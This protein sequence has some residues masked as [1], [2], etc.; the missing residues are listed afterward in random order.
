[1]YWASSK[2]RRA[3]PF[4]LHHSPFD[5]HL[6]T[7]NFTRP[8]A[9]K[10][11]LTSKTPLDM[12]Q[13]V[14]KRELAASPQQVQNGPP[15]IDRK[16]VAANARVTMN[17]PP[18]TNQ[19]RQLQAPPGIP[20]RGLVNVQNSSA[21]LQHASRRRHSG[22][23]NKGDMYDTDADSIDTTV[24]QSVIQVEDS[25]LKEPQ[26]LQHHEP[27][28]LGS[29]GADEDEDEAADYDDD[30]EQEDANEYD[31]VDMTQEES[32]YLQRQ[33]KSHLTAEDALAYLAQA[34][35]EGFP[36]VDG[37]SYPTTTDGEPTEWRG[38]QGL[39]PDSPSPRRSV[40]NGHRPMAQPS[41][42]RQ[43]QGGSNA[44]PK[45]SSKKL[46]QQSANIRDQQ[47]VNAYHNPQL[48]QGHHPMAAPVQPSQPPSYSQVKHEFP[49]PQVVS[50][51]AR[52]NQMAFN[53]APQAFP[54]QQPGPAH[55][56]IAHLSKDGAHASS[57]RNKHVP[58]IQKSAPMEQ[59]LV[60]DPV[61]RPTSDYDPEVLHKMSY[62]QLKNE[63]FD[64]NPRANGPPLSGDMLQKPL[65]ERLEHVQKNFDPIKQSEFFQT[66]PTHEWEDAGDWF[67]EQF[68]SIINRTKEARKQKR[69]LAE[70]FEDEIEKRHKHVSKKYRQVG[71]AMKKMQAQGEGLVP[72]SPRPSKSPNPKKR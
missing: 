7:P 57:T 12:Q 44:L 50:A 24:N 37:D 25:Q 54:P 11:V 27:V 43:P 41:M 55:A 1:M 51:N 60:Q 69:K 32:D 46:F 66:L 18:A 47:R 9:H 42:Q 56:Q 38:E 28:D 10:L 68:S 5:V 3:F 30:E 39:T 53:Q 65:V 16:A 72:R 48:D 71:D 62:D 36:T 33:G 13:F 6:T 4:E 63:S 52:Q 34:R 2:H 26:Y 15:S 20:C 22:Q 21:A 19:T 59:V 17:K 61:V 45:H 35:S 58:I 40:M 14:A 67:L 23:G 29:E 64:A 70:S 31:E 49:T 8:A